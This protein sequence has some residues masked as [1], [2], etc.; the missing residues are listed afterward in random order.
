[1]CAACLTTTG[2]TMAVK[3]RLA[4]TGLTMAVKHCLAVKLCLAHSPFQPFFDRFQPLSTAFACIA[5]GRQSAA[6]L[7]QWSI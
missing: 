5:L 3:L 7:N 4:T 1:M 2:L 6:C